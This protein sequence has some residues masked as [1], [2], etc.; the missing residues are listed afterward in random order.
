MP[1]RTLTLRSALGLRGMRASIS[2]EAPKGEGI[3]PGFRLSRFRLRGYN[4]GMSWSWTTCRPRTRELSNPQ[5]V[6]IFVSETD[7]MGGRKMNSAPL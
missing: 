7:P 4:P 1:F 6:T 5:N 2:V 3:L